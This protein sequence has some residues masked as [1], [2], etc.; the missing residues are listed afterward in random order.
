MTIGEGPK[1]QP[2]LESARDLGLIQQDVKRY[3]LRSSASSHPPISPCDPWGRLR[4][5]LIA[6]AV[7]SSSTAYAS[8]TWSCRF[9]TLVSESVQAA[10]MSQYLHP[11]SLELVYQNVS[12]HCRFELPCASLGLCSKEELANQGCQV[13]LKMPCT[14][15]LCLVS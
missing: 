4:L 6:R 7:C 13:S 11:D 1:A 9:E 3:I 5:I 8:T 2:G 10:S 15:T 12:H 14:I